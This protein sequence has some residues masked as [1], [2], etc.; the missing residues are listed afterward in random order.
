VHADVYATPHVEDGRWGV[1]HR[2]DAAVEAAVE[3]GGDPLAPLRQIPESPTAYARVAE[4]APKGPRYVYAGRH[5]Y[6]F[7]HFLIETL[8]RLWP[9]REGLPDDVVLVMHGD[10]TPEAWFRIAYVR[11]VLGALGITP[12]R[13]LHIDRPL[14]FDRLETPGSAFLPGAAA[15]PA[16]V[17]LTRAIGARLA[18]DLPQRP[19][20]HRPAFFAKTRLV[21]GVSHL[22]NEPELVAELQRRGVEIVHPQ[23]MRFVEHM[24]FLASRRVVS[25]WLSSAHHVSL[26]TPPGRFALLAPERPNA[27]FFLIDKLTGARADYWFAEGTRNLPAQGSTFIV[28]RRVGD[29]VAT[30]R[31]LLE[32]F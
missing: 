9:W 14:R 22:Q 17:R 1:F 21:G 2:D 3:R 30:A 28:E 19:T 16:F 11:T 4:V 13:I 18:P 31:A 15:H 25:G 12:G 32:V 24:R 29:P 20:V 6:H 27:N 23:E 7:G 10:D 26:F 8:A 5:V